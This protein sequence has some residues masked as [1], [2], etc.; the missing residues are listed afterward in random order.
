MKKLLILN[1]SPRKKG[2]T[3]ILS[4]YLINHLSADLQAEQLFLY[5][6]NLNPCTDCR[7]CKEGDLECIIDDGMIEL[8]SKINEADILVLGTPIYWFGPSAQTKMLLDRLRPYYVN[9]KL[10]GKK[11]ALILP[12][13]TGASDCDLTIEIFIRSFKALGVEYVDA[14]T[15]ESYDAGDAYNDEQALKDIE[16][17]AKKIA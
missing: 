7:A 1:G 8:Y 4:E 13:G 5:D 11:A 3:A 10:D 2:N 9:K 17:L 12:A 6:Y 16:S 14:I 15:S